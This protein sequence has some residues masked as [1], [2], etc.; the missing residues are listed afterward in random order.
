MAKFIYALFIVIMITVS[1]SRAQLFS[2]SA[3]YFLA[4]PYSAYGPYP[5]NPAHQASVT[6][7]VG[8]NIFCLDCGRG[9]N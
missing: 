2:P 6:G 9:R 8:A 7:G 3:A 1:L 5:Y 4:M